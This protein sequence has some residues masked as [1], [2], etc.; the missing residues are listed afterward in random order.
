MVIVKG[1]WS[2]IEEYPV[3]L[4]QSRV[5]YENATSDDHAIDDTM[6]SQA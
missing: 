3:A 6:P 4:R 5:L 1:P 2:R